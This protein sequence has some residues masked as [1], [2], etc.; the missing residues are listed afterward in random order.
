MS[1]DGASAAIAACS[2][3]IA[4]PAAPRRVFY[5]LSLAYAQAGQDS[6]ALAQLQKAASLGHGLA[7]YELAGRYLAG[8]GVPKDAIKALSLYYKAMKKVGG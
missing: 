2:K 4:V 8:R 1:G 3:A 5:Q 7:L 6:L